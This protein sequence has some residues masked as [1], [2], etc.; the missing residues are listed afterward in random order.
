MS[1][2]NAKTEASPH[3]T[4]D[5][6]YLRLLLIVLGTAT[7]FEGY[8]SAISA[9]VLQDLARSFEVP[10]DETAS[11]TGPIIPVGLG[12]F[13]ALLVTMLGDRIGRRPL[14]IG[15]TFAYALFTGLTATANDLP[16]FVVYQF[17]AR[18]FLLAEYATAVTI[19]TEEFPAARRGRALGT[20]TALGALG[21]PI[22]AV[23]NLWAGRSPEGWRILY[24]VGLIPLVVVGFLRMKLKETSRWVESRALSTPRV[25]RKDRLKHVIALAHPGTLL[26]VGGLYFFSH[27]ALLA[28]ATWWPF[29]AGV[30]LGFSDG[31]IAT[32]LGIA[33]PLGVSGYYLAG[34]LQDRYGRRRTGALFLVFG[35]VFGILVFQLDSAAW[36]FPAMILAVF[37][38]FGM[39]PVLAAVASELFPTSI[40]ATAV[41]VVRSVFGTVGGIIGPVTVGILA[42]P[43]VA[44]RLP[45]WPVFGDL[46]DSVCVAILANIPAL[47]LL[48]SLPETAGRELESITAALDTP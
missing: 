37:F 38:G 27:F 35:M 20:L 16:T 12:A 22:V 31:K 45:G 11:I 30:R 42:D 25:S 48:M 32:L 40:R 46:G 21:L 5:S 6:S 8:D 7:F 33:Y 3:A 9:V 41:G 1:S 10:L 24:L 19:V 23:L 28:A 18:S 29:Y 17:F 15:T 44:E 14:L 13:G 4:R 34:R 43:R 39:N 26:K 47:L 2:L 36:M